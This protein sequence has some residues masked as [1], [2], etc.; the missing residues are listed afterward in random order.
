MDQQPNYRRRRA[1]VAAAALALLVL[2][3]R[4]EPTFGT[5]SIAFDGGH[6]PRIDAALAP[7]L[8]ALAAA[9]TFAA[10]RLVR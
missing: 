7:P 1:A 3:N 4:D 5:L 9:A 2:A 6:A 10:E 8:D